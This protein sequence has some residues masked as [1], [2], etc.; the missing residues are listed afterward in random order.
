MKTVVKFMTYSEEQGQFSSAHLF[1]FKHIR[2]V[3]RIYQAGN[4]YKHNDNAE[5]MTL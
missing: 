2:I 3:N 1:N 4:Q 5:I